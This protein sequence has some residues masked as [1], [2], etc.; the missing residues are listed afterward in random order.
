MDRETRDGRVHYKVRSETIIALQS[1][2]CFLSDKLSLLAYFKFDRV[3]L[4]VIKVTGL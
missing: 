1:C 3:R 4:R 2:A